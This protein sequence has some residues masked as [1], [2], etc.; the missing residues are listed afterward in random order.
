MDAQTLKESRL[1][2]EELLEEVFCLQSDLKLYKVDN[3]LLRRGGLISKHINDLGVNKSMV[4]SLS[5]TQNQE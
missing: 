2:A 3:S 1:T 5:G 4:T